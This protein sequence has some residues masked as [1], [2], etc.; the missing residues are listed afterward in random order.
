[1]GTGTGAADL[2]HL[3]GFVAAGLDVLQG[4]QDG[5]LAENCR[6]KQKKGSQGPDSRS[7]VNPPGQVFGPP[8]GGC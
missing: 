3:V 1:M 5:G 7:R 2:L 4:L 8:G 6:G